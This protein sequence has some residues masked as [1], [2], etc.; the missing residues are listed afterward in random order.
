MKL[1]ELKTSLEKRI[2]E[3]DEKIHEIEEYLRNQKKPS[4]V[5]QDTVR[6]LRTKRNEIVLEY[7]QL[8]AMDTEDEVR[9]P[10]LQK[11]IYANLEAFDSV[12]SKAGSLY[13]G[14]RFRNRG[15][16][17]DFKDPMRTK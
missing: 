5:L 15:R 1:Q 10:E 4:P 8:A 7:D 12:F 11:S 6:Q 17:I 14:S 13:E 9:M 3:I 2:V 16:D